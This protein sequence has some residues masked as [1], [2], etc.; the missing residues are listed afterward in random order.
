[1]EQKKRLEKTKNLLLKGE[2]ERSIKHCRGQFNSIESE[3]KK[4]APEFCKE[5]SELIKRIETIGDSQ[6]ENLNLFFDLKDNFINLVKQITEEIRGVKEED[7]GRY[8]YCLIPSPPEIIN[9]GE[10]GLFGKEVYTIQCGKISAVVSDMPVKDYKMFD[11]EESVKIHNNVIEHVMGK[12]IT[13]PLAYNQ[14]WKNKE[15][16]KIFIEKSR[17]DIHITFKKLEGKLEFGI[18]VFKNNG[19]ALENEII[20]N[21]RELP[22][23]AECVKLG[24]KFNSEIILNAFYLVPKDRIEEFSKKVENMKNKC[25]KLRI[26]FTGPWPPYNFVEMRSGNNV[27]TG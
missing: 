15:L 25:K 19:L 2:V 5:L 18:K 16:L 7:L 27:H 13:I 22:K 24:K 4:Y 10:I 21:L 20:E 8:V 9:F 1:M 23:T 12:F 14:T 11:F 17:E 3:V 26:E 6:S